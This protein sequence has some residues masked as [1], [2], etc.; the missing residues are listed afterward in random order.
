MSQGDIRMKDKTY[1]TAPAAVTAREHLAASCFSMLAEGRMDSLGSTY[2]AL[3]PDLFKRIFGIVRAH[4]DAEDVLHDVFVR[5]AVLGPKAVTVE[6]PLGYL[7]IMARNEALK[8]LAKIQY[9]NLADNQIEALS[10]LSGGLALQYIELSRNRVKDLRPLTGLTN[11]ASLYLSNNQ[12]SDLSPIIKFPKLA[13]LYLDNNQL[14]SIQ[15]VNG[16]A[17]LTTLS[18]NNNSI[19]DLSPLDGLNGLYYLFLENN[20][21]RDLSPLVNMVKKDNDGPKRFAPFINIYLK[22]NSP[23]GGQISALKQ[24]DARVNN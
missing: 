11:L 7:F 14:K 19:S 5:L 23:K 22:G 4:E 20:K 18:L 9:L 21:I 16:L 8:T 1:S 6:R 3:R 15:G 12:I 13:S 24:N 10:P 2:S 17:N